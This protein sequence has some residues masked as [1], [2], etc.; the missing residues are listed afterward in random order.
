MLL[1][2]PVSTGGSHDSD[3]LVALTSVMRTL[4]GSDN[5]AANTDAIHQTSL[6]QNK[7]RKTTDRQTDNTHMD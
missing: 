5:G 4:R 2:T 3:I 1:S 6:T 7:T